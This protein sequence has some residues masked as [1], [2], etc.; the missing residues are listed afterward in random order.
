VIARAAVL[1]AAALA[2][3]YEELRACAPS[4]S[5]PMPPGCD[6]RDL[7]VLASALALAAAEAAS[8]GRPLCELV[9]LD[10][11]RLR[12]LC[13]R[14]FPGAPLELEG[15][16]PLAVPV[17][18]ERLR[19]L[20]RSCATAPQPLAEEL[21]CIVAR[22]AQRPRHLWQDLGLASRAEL[23][24]LMA[25][26]FAPLQARNRGDMKWKKFFART[27]CAE[28]LA[29]VCAAPSCGECDDVDACFGPEAGESSL[30]HLRRR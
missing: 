22:R 10:P 11:L 5:G 20:L 6:A 1:D 8:E 19:D 24:A 27:L 29:P 23:S 17:E 21:A 30:L 13:A 28:G 25:R 2:A 9:G 15:G 26:R 16:A 3:L 14:L 7:H 4:G 18:E 12:G